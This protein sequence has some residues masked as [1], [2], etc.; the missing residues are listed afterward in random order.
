[1]LIRNHKNLENSEKLI[2]DNIEGLWLKV[3]QGRGTWDA[4]TRGRRDVGLGDAGMR[5]CGTW[6]V[7]F[8]D[9]GTWDM[10]M[11]ELRDVGTQG[12]DKQTKPLDG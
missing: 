1:M 4:R 8:R 3:G 12:R 6:D 9:N 7:G 10:R 5:G 11:Q 2:S